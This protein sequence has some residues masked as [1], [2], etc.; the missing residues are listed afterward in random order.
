M[1]TVD[2]FGVGPSSES[3]TTCP[4]SSKSSDVVVVDACHMPSS[5]LA[6]EVMLVILLLGSE[7]DVC[8]LLLRTESA[9]AVNW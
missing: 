9:L 7:G 2:H 4:E 1:L 5:N 3:G 8:V 6:I